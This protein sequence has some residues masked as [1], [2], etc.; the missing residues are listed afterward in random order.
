MI[1]IILS[2]RVGI[3]Y[4]ITPAGTS[5]TVSHTWW[6]LCSEFQLK[7]NFELGN[8]RISFIPPLVTSNIVQIYFTNFST[9]LYFFSQKKRKK[10]FVFDLTKME[11]D[12]RKRSQIHRTIT[13]EYR[14]RK[15]WT[16]RVKPNGESTYL[17]E[18]KILSSKFHVRNIAKTRKPDVHSR[19]SLENIMFFFFCDSF[20]CALQDEW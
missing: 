12:D 11:Y 4:V 13:F 20:G 9:N 19:R 2:H 6:K 3:A 10:I 5:V 7:F 1:H 16:K 8:F 18:I 14:Y 15:I 17:D